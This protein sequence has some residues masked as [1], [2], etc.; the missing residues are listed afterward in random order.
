MSYLNKSTDKK[1]KK[2]VAP[3][4]SVGQTKEALYDKAAMGGSGYKPAS[5]S[6]FGR[7]K[8]TR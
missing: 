8:G 1:S 6:M 4:D 5:K 7:R 3:V 2:S